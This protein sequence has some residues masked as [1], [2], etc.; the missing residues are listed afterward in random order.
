MSRA[1]NFSMFQHCVYKVKVSSFSCC[2]HGT[3][4]IF[5]ACKERVL[6][7][8]NNHILHIL[9]VVM[10]AFVLCFGFVSIHN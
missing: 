9:I 8:D 6:C 2:R 5:S 3:R 1:V 4:E 10:V 7:S